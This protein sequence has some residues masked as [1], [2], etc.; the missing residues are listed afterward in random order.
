LLEIKKGIK[1]LKPILKR[2]LSILIVAIVGCIF[3][4]ASIR[5]GGSV[6]F[7]DGPFREN[8]GIFI[9][10]VV[11][12]NFLFGFVYFAAGVGLWVQRR[13][14]VWISL[15]VAIATLIVFTILVIYIVNGGTYELRT[16]YAMILRFVVWVLITIV[17]YIRIIK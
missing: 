4:L 5:S 9:P 13:W 10:F 1:M 16:I 12:F 11:W 6:L 3:G 15:L 17:G 7:I 8:V 14:A 2:P